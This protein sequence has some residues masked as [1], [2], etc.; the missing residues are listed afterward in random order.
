[1][2]QK[3]TPGVRRRRHEAAATVLERHG[4][5]PRGRRNESVQA[6]HHAGHNDSDLLVG[7]SGALYWLSAGTRDIIRQ[8]RRGENDAVDAALNAVRETE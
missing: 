1:M 3:T 4:W 8:V 2:N 6:Y 7:T 5:R